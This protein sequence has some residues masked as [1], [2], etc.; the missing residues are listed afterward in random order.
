MADIDKVIE[1]M[2]AIGKGLPATDGVA[3]FNTLYLAVT[4]EVGKQA[5]GGRFKDPE[6][7]ALLDVVFADLYFK[8]VDDSGAGRKVNRAWAP[9]F[10][11]RKRKR[12]ASVQFALAGMN[13]HINHDLVLAIV[14]TC[15]RLDRPVKRGSAFHKDYLVVNELL[16]Q[17]EERIKGEFL[18]GDLKLADDAL[19]R[20]DDVLAMWSV[21]R[22]RD[23]AW[24]WAE[25]LTQLPKPLR[26]PFL[27]TLASKVGF[28]GRGLLVPVG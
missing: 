27:D 8:A 23:A 2:T 24:T 25:T 9:L 28:A 4:R 5:A 22:A 11:S 7:L 21:A 16:E 26:K 13:A 14:E 3:R 15:R 20:L 18:T 1:R 12:I 19:G 17:V 10:E 6:A